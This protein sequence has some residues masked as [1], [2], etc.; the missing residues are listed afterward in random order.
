MVTKQKIRNDLMIELLNSMFENHKTSISEKELFEML[1]VK[2][3]IKLIIR[4]G[5]W[6][7]A[8]YKDGLWS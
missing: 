3:G 2:I 7:Q 5:K 1:T 6:A 4:N 8:E